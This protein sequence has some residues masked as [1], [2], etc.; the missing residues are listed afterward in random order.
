MKLL[1]CKH[2][3]NILSYMYNVNTILCTHAT[4]IQHM[5]SMSLIEKYTY[6]YIYTC[7]IILIVYILIYYVVVLYY[8][9]NEYTCIIYYVYIQH[10]Q[11]A[12]HMYMYI[13]SSRND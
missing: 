8:Y 12:M 9:I 6:K 13:Y 11:H 3:N 5:Q 4:C 10:V 1:V 2:I 7:I